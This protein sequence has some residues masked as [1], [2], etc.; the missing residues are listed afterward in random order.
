[1]GPVLAARVRRNA[2]GDYAYLAARRNEECHRVL[3]G[4]TG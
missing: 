2:F 4:S 1:M 3:I